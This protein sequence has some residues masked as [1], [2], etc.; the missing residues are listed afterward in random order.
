MMEFTV[1]G[2]A[3]KGG[4]DAVLSLVKHLGGSLFIGST[5]LFP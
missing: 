3:L 4:L 5:S 2:P 1:V